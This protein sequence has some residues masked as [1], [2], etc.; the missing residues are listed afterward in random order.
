MARALI[1]APASAKRGEVI[2]IRA[3]LQ[4]PMETGFRPGDDGKIQARDIVTSFTC[5]YDGA[6]VFAAE[7]FA[8]VAANP[9]LSFHTV[10][11]ATGTL[12]FDWIGDNG[13]THSETHALTVTG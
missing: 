6:P 13:F 5:T 7:L 9:Y 2:E 8:A 12:K 1:T 10:A 11:T 3:L 4:H